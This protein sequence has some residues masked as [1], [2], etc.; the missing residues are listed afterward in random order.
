MALTIAIQKDIGIDLARPDGLTAFV[1][2]IL[3]GARENVQRDG[4][5][6]PIAFFVAHRHPQT[7]APF[8]TGT[9][10]VAILEGSFSDKERAA[11]DLA[12]LGTACDASALIMCSEAW[13]KTPLGQTMGEILIC[14][15]EA[16]DGAHDRM[17][18][19]YLQ[20]DGDSV[21]ASDW[22]TWDATQAQGMFSRLLG[23]R[24]AATR[25]DVDA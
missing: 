15:V 22:H 19:S 2:A 17:Y 8:A 9:P 18:V 5:L 7:G 1:Q 24:R 3:D 25:R 12:S 4:H 20:R 14:N 10:I 16:R 6:V 11:S 21:S 13:E 23:G